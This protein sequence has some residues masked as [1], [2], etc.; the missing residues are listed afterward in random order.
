MAKILV[1]IDDALLERVDA[2][3]TKRQMTRSAWLARVA[4]RELGAEVGPGAGPEAHEA[5][6]ALD[7][8]FRENPASV[9][10][11]TILVRRERDAR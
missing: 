10:D 6:R 5:L 2:E 7:R 1:S 3:R 11:S 8:L 4:E 9:E